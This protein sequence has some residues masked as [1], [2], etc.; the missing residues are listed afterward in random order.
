MEQFNVIRRLRF[1]WNHRRRARLLGE[2]IEAHLAMKTAGLMENGMTESDARAEARRR[3]GNLTHT[4]E[5]SRA[6]W[7]ARWLSDLLHDLAFAARTFRAQP[8]FTAVAVLSSALGI[9][10]CATI[11]GIANVAL[12]RPLPVDAPTRLMSICGRSTKTGEIGTEMSYPNF[13]DV[14]P[15]RS[16][17]AVAGYFPIVPAT[18][19]SHGEP[20]RYFGSLVTANYFDVVRPGFRLGRGF[21]PAH[22]DTPGAPPAVVL[23][24]QLWQSRFAA[25]PNIIGKSID[26]NQ[27]PARVVGVVAPGFRGTELALI[28]DFWW[29]LSMFDQ[30]GLLNAKGNHMAERGD[31]WIF[32]IGRLRDGVATAQAEA[33][34][35][36]IGRRLAAQYPADNRDTTLHLETAGRVNPGL[37]RVV[38]TFFLLL[39]SVT[40]LVLLTACANVANLLLARA[41][42]R[43]KE[44]ATRLA[45]GAGRGRLVRQLLAESVLLALAGGVAGFLLAL[46]AASNIGKFRLPFPIPVD[47]TITLDYRVV[48]FSASLAMLTG[49]VFGLAPALRASHTDLTAALKDAPSHGRGLRRFG[50]R[51]LLVVAQVAVC[52]LLLIC[53]TLFLR[54]LQASASANTGMANRNVLCLAFDPT[55]NHYTEVRSR[56]FMSGLLERVE[57]VPGVQSATLTTL[58]PLSLANIDARIVPDDKM[59]DAA[60]NGLDTELYAVAPRFFETLGIPLRAGEDFRAG[61]SASED[62][63]IVN[64]T[65][66]DKAFPRQNPIGR[67]VS[68]ESRMVR[69]IGVV[70]TAK[71]QSIGEDPR[72]A[73]YVPLLRS[74]SENLLGVTLLV[75]TA[76][77]PAAFA[78]PVRNVMH[79]LDSAL[80]VF[81]V[82]TM[83]AHLSNA[84]TFPRMAAVM[85]GLCGAMALLI[86]IVGLYGVVSF[87]VARRTREIGI[88][89]ALGAARAQ[90][91][92]MVLRQ[93]LS[94]AAAGCLIGLLMALAFTRAAAGLLYGVT[95][96]DP[97]TFVLT[98]LVLISVALAACLIPARRAATLNPTRSLRYE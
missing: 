97:M 98:P 46:W 22:D 24:Y 78:T 85:F 87:A 62:V 32:A 40:I 48:L 67:H 10:A 33:E 77:D 93:G 90:V 86:S 60:K 80:A 9:G 94:L 29:P 56:Q 66:A 17:Q 71:A 4:L 89:M 52:M 75:K 57:A 31:H 95:A 23:S 73:F 96:S 11:F 74:P 50:M 42:A 82:R 69:I 84:L 41:S 43:H 79:S 76:G 81:D 58:V 16:F 3:F 72:P 36:V 91:L 7:I 61:A 44:I 37:R 30:V 28:S 39:M 47:L 38:Q 92:R 51:N 18:I 35:A 14:R 6:V 70:A 1:W 68:Y 25:D 26:M 27:R 2:E 8:A 54:S 88:R 53:S 49:I 59:S 15:A 21:D 65:L 64:Q 13:L 19:S 20:Q 83:Q 63:G 12:F 5:D 55:L 45:I 34:V